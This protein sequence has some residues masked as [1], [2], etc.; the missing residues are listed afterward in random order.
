M[1]GV[2]TGIVVVSAL[3]VSDDT[4]HQSRRKCRIVDLVRGNSAWQLD[5]QQ[6]AT[7]SEAARAGQDRES[8]PDPPQT[9][10]LSVI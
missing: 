4:R 10:A 7:G 8:D 9:P 1:D 3:E 5:V 2:A 6:V